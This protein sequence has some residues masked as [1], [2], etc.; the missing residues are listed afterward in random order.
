MEAIERERTAE[1]S[2]LK[3]L[4]RA[5]GD[6]DIGSGHVMRC[7]ALAEELKRHNNAV[8]LHARS[9]ARNLADRCQGFG[10][11][12]SE[13]HG[14]I[15]NAEDIQTTLDAADEFSADWVVL[16]GYNLPNKM[17]KA[18]VETGHRV[19]VID[20]GAQIGSYSSHL[21]TDPNPAASPE[22]YVQREPETDL[23]LG[24]RY[25]LIRREFQNTR[26][27][28]PPKP[29]RV[30]RIVA[31]LGGATPVPVLESIIH[32]VPDG[33]DRILVIAPDQPSNAELSAIAQQ[34]GWNVVKGTAHMAETLAMADL[35]I[36]AGGS[37]NWEA[38]CL[39]LPRMLVRLAGNQD[40]IVD[41]L[42]NAGIGIDLG[43]GEGLTEQT[44]QNAF[45]AL[46]TDP[47][48]LGQMAEAAWRLIDGKGTGR[49]TAALHKKGE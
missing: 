7:L 8:I 37:T 6:A 45:S 30:K 3:I 34:K 1:G 13:N 42:T 12:V 15:G 32:G 38:C 22:E 47:T 44:I 26:P 49:I 23:L 20:D 25:A 5:D 9:L 41:Y 33:L 48:Y 39:G 27:T 16:D 31:S 17:Q 2:S 21:V 24:P 14:P 28:T 40:D 19:I 4:I 11:E 43:Q 29:R 10:V 36:L 35:L 46:D 18:L